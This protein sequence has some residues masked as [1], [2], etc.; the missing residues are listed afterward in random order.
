MVSSC[1]LSVSK[2]GCFG[3]NKEKTKRVPSAPHRLGRWGQVGFFLP[4]PLFLLTKKWWCVFIYGG[5]IIKGHFFLWVS[6]VL[7]DCWGW[8]FWFP[9]FFLLWSCALTAEPLSVCKGSLFKPRS[10]CVFTL[11]ACSLTYVQLCVYIY[12]TKVIFI[13]FHPTS[14]FVS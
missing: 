8:S 3:S 6:Q 10:K 13:Y 4:Q 11:L 1:V 12:Y 14:Q 9:L 7:P 2:R 5:N